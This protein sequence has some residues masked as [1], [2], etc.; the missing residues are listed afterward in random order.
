MTDL[1]DKTDLTSSGTSEAE[2]Q[3]AIGALYDYVSQLVVGQPP[4]IN[5]IVL[6][7]ITPSST[8]ITVDTESDTSADDLTNIVPTNIGAKVI[9]VR[10]E[11]S[12]R[13]VTLKHNSGGTG[14][15]WNHGA[16]D[17]VLD[18]INKL[19]VFY[20]NPDSTRWEELWRNWGVFTTGAGDRAAALTAI[21]AGT[22]ATK[23]TGTLSGQVPTNA[24]LGALS[25]VS[26]ITSLTQIANLL[27]TGSKIA[28]GTLAIS[29]F[30]NDTAN[31]LYRL[32]AS[33]VPELLTAPGGTGQ[34][35]RSDLSFATIPPGV[36][37]IGQAETRTAIAQMS[38]TGPFRAVSRGDNSDRNG[39]W[40][41]DAIT[42]ASGEYGFGFTVK[43]ASSYT[44]GVM[45]GS[46]NSSSYVSQAVPW[47]MQGIAGEGGGGSFG[48]LYVSMQARERYLTASP[49]FSPYDDGGEA[50]GFMFLL[51]NK[52]G[53]IASGY[54]ADVPSWAYNGPTD[55]TP[56][57]IDEWGVKYKSKRKKKT[58]SEL[59]LQNKG[60]SKICPS[61]TF[62]FEDRVWMATYGMTNIEEIKKVKQNI[63]DTE[64]VVITNEMKNADRELIPHPFP[65]KRDDQTVVLVGLYDDLL[66]DLVQAVN[67]GDDVLGLVM[68]GHLYPD[69][70]TFKKGKTVGGVKL[71]DLKVR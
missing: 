28:N 15:F 7:S 46:N 24:D 42:R 67:E 6:G 58:R 48:D 39:L 71:V 14:M 51:I 21:G 10:S 25:L 31:S 18:N 41:S 68:D 43:C 49:P 65:A 16:V 63:L 8:F 57:H 22:A 12:A 11:S 44:S 17:V 5:S 33:G 9:F 50:A 20:Y 37:T 64:Y 40:W 55:I 45:A 36:T 66:Y 27:I 56:D 26:Q 70:T 3:G 19:I 38:W 59:I 1:P 32:N 13:A 23:D 54:L 2:F 30:A 53:S 52:D 60:S 4:E 61:D 29:K 69:L 35:L 47:V 62:A 34:W